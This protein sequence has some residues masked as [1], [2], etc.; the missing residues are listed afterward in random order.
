MLNLAMRHPLS[1]WAT[2]SA[3][4]LAAFIAEEEQKWNLSGV[5]P[6]NHP[7]KRLGQYQ[8]WIEACPD[9]PQRL[10]DLGGKLPRM[11]ANQSTRTVRKAGD[12]GAWRD[13]LRETI[14]GSAIGGTRL[15]TLV[16]DG[17]MPL[18]ASR[19][20]DINLFGLWYHWFLGDVPRRIVTV[21]RQ[22]EPPESDAIVLCQGRV[23][24]LLGWLIEQELA[25]H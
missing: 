10:Q 7:R 25:D 11:S 13:R 15:D 5:R 12:L 9:W 22:A 24:G 4:P 21:L 20:D 1:A 2:G 19:G 8:Q 17:F 23:Q 6:A 14:T 16:C 3:L 18:L